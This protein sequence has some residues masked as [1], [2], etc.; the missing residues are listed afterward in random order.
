MMAVHALS[1]RSRCT[2]LSSMHNSQ[3][4]GCWGL[5]GAHDESPA[6]A[7]AKAM[8][9][10]RNE[11]MST[12]TSPPR[13]ARTSTDQ[14]ATQAEQAA[15][16]TA[17]VTAIL[18]GERIIIAVQID[19]HVARRLSPPRSG[20]E[21][22]MPALHKASNHGEFARWYGRVPRHSIEREGGAHAPKSGRLDRQGQAGHPLRADISPMPTSAPV[23]RCHERR[24]AGVTEQQ[25]KTH[26]CEQPTSEATEFGIDHEELRKVSV[27]TTPRSAVYC[28]SGTARILICRDR[29]VGQTCTGF[30]VALWIQ[31]PRTVW[32]RTIDWS[33]KS[34]QRFRRRASMD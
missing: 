32:T 18:T 34:P 31:S 33:I 11:G 30:S 15:S 22:Q 13:Y 28:G 5:A 16:R 17:D 10:H 26:G 24:R 19:A 23:V 7:S 21:L 25:N 4:C 14:V 3:S 29:S 12:I 9:A 20:A 8:I 6:T 2:K 1:L 27:E